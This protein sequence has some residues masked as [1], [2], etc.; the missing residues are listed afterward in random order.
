MVTQFHSE[1]L[2]KFC[3]VLSRQVKDLIYI[4]KYCFGCLVKNGVDEDKSKSWGELF[5]VYGIF[6]VRDGGGWI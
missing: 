2:E 1:Y 6:Q 5:K 4:K 3:R